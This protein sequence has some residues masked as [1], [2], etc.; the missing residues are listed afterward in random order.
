MRI[1]DGYKVRIQDTGPPITDRD[2]DACEE[3]LQVRLPQ[4]YRELLLRTNGGVP[5]PGGMVYKGAAIRLERLYS[6][7]SPLPDGD[8]IAVCQRLRGKHDLPANFIA[9][10][11]AEGDTNFVLVDCLSTPPGKLYYWLMAEL[12][13]VTAGDESPNVWALSYSVGDIPGKLGPQRKREDVDGLFSRLFWIAGNPQNGSKII[14]E[15]VAAGYDINFVLPNCKHPVFIALLGHA[16]SVVQTM[17]ELGTRPDHVDEKNV[18]LRN[19]LH[20]DLAWWRDRLA[21]RKKGETVFET[22][23]RNIRAIEAALSVFGERST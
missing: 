11:K 19:R 8:V 3:Q 2:L 1:R 10:A 6:V 17:V 9:V 14:R 21:E 4:D 13:F 23:R 12:G 15:F 7:A 16:Y 22:A 20:Q 5:R 18:T